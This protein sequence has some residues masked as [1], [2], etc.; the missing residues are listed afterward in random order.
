MAVSDE[1]IAIAIA[2]L[3]LYFWGMNSKRGR[4]IRLIASVGMITCGLTLVTISDTI[5][6]YM[7]FGVAII[8]AGFQI[9]HDV[10]GLVGGKDEY[11]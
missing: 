4:I 5:A 11:H 1:F 8:I 6:M 3:L 2:M 9:F 7:L 10:S